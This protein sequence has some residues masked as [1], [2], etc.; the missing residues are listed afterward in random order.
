MKVWFLTIAYMAIVGGSL[1]MMEFARQFSGTTQLW[2]AHFLEKK[3]M[4]LF[5][6]YQVWSYSWRFIIFGTLMQLAAVWVWK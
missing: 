2:E 4:G 5:N 3:V 1:G 6:G